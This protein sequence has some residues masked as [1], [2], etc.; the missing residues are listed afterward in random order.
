METNALSFVCVF[1]CIMLACPLLAQ[2][3][4]IGHKSINQVMGLQRSEIA[5]LPVDVTHNRPTRIAIPFMDKSRTIELFPHSVRSK[6]FKL[7]VEHNGKLS[8]VAAGDQGN[9]F[10]GRMACMPTARVSATFMNKGWHMRI[11]TECG[12]DYWLE[13]AKGR[14][15]V[16]GFKQEDHI[17][18]RVEDILSSNATCAATAALNMSLDASD[19]GDAVLSP[20]TGAGDIYVAEIAIDADYEY[21]L[22]L[23]AD[24]SNTTARIESLINAVNIQ[25][26][27]DVGITHRISAIIVR[28]DAN[29]PYTETDAV[30]LLDQLKNH[31]LRSQNNINYDIA[32]LFTGKDVSYEGDRNTIGLAFQGVVCGNSRFGV[33][34]AG[35]SS[36]FGS[37][38]DLIAHELGHN[39]NA[40]HCTCSNHTMNPSITSTNV[41]NPEA[42]IPAIIAF[43]DSLSCLDVLS[44]I[45]PASP[46]NLEAIA[47]NF[48]TVQVMWQDNSSIELGFD[49]ERSLD[50]VTWSLI[51]SVGADITSYTDTGLNAETTYYYRTQAYNAMGSSGFS[52]TSMATT[53]QMPTSID[54]Y[55]WSESSVS[56]SVTGSYTATHFDD[57]MPQVIQEQS[58][59]GKPPFN[60][61]LLQHQWNFSVIDGMAVTVLANAWM[62]PSGDGD[63]FQFSY[64]LNNGAFVDMFTLSATHPGNT[65]SFVLPPEAAGNVVIR[66]IDTQRAF[67][68][69]SLDRLYVD[70]LIIRTEFQSLEPPQAPQNLRLSENDAP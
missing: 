41:F 7:L 55:A 66:V 21:F 62:D 43:R 35:W 17:L 56:G 57:D 33:S 48:K 3:G 42:T 5:Q 29:D 53:P 46:S 1:L 22:S 9:T 10:R 16:S 40:G 32:H 12:E 11:T 13:P 61:S 58:S 4:P 38:T 27:R 47:T 64:S 30:K 63:T 54:Q 67:R 39:W 36:N 68:A 6:H 26:E 60:Y 44:E 20:A 28:S 15:G 2:P 45:P 49:I 37:I 52:N 19:I 69:T 65:E 59:G 50:G 23:G 70:Q 51:A 25:Y 14:V 31:F 8:E 34:E 18:Y 24:V